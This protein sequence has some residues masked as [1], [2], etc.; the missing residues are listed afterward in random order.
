[1]QLVVIES[2]LAGDFEKNIKYARLCALDCLQKGEAPYASHLFFT[3][4]LN[5]E[6][7]EQRNLGINAGFLWAEKAVKRIVYTDFGISYGMSKGIKRGA[8]IGQSLEYRKL[9]A[10][11][12]EKLE[13]ANDLATKGA[14]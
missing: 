13:S 9:P 7:I 6:N 2:P 1:M 10:D 8:E 3:Q 11:L 12:M 4:M 5:D 14:V